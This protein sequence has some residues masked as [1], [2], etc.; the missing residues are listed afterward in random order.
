[1]TA[2]SQLALHVS[3]SEVL[4]VAEE[5]C[6]KR[7]AATLV[8]RLMIETAMYACATAGGLPFPQSD[9]L[10]I[11][12]HMQNLVSTANHRDA[13]SAG[14]MP[15]EIRVFP[16]G[17]LDVDDKFYVSVMGP[18]VQAKFADNFQIWARYYDSWFSDYQHEDNPDAAEMLNRLEEPFATEF[19]IT[20]DQLMS[21]PNSFGRYARKTNALVLEFDDAAI[22]L[23]L[24]A[25]CALPISAVETFLTRFSLYP[26]P[27]W[28][29]NLPAEMKDHDVFPWRFRRR[30][31]LL[32][33]PIVQVRDDPQK[34]W[35]V[36]PPALATTAKY[37]LDNVATAD[38]PVEHFTSDAMRQFW[39]DQ[40]NRQGHRFENE[41]ADVF[42][43]AGFCALRQVPMR[44]MGVS[45]VEGDL[46][47][48]DVLAWKIGQ[49][50]VLIVECKR[51][52][53]ARSVRDV[54]DRLDK[55]R[56]EVGDD[57]SK[58]LRRVTWLRQH[59][60]N[61]RAKCVRLPAHI[62]IKPLLVTS[63]LMPMQF[64]SRTP[65]KENEVVSA[66]LLPQM[67]KK[68]QSESSD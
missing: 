3:Q 21:I 41:V 47:D 66:D 23:F 67:L 48:I 61:L 10:E 40:V 53:D 7:D 5:R 2:R 33:R 59:I 52:R 34:Q 11:L 4:E 64:I 17:E 46:G 15:A 68:L 30:L 35:L 8:N 9:H 42:E 50:V 63:A 6:G 25:E 37:V 54:V 32:M 27:V 60:E 13:M 19:G 26:R 29:Q 65:L 16:N 45:D 62:E 14:F 1:M 44:A 55:Y 51:L 38:F 57:L 56:G 22:R 20:I 43:Q 58:H 28:D 31:S 24:E 18:Y 36:F 49:P 12:A 39:G